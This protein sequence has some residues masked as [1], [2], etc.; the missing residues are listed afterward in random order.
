MMWG[1][2]R[3]SSVLAPLGQKQFCGF[4]SW[5]FLIWC[6]WCLHEVYLPFF[7]FFFN[8]L[9]ELWACGISS[10]MEL[11]MERL[12]S[13]LGWEPAP[14]LAAQSL[15][16][17]RKKSFLPSAEE[18]L[19]CSLQSPPP[20]VSSGHHHICTFRA[21][22]VA[23]HT[24]HWT[25][26]PVKC[27]AAASCSTEVMDEDAAAVDTGRWSC[28]AWLFPQNFTVPCH[29]SPSLTKL[30]RP[31]Q[32]AA[33]VCQWALCSTKSKPL[34]GMGKWTRSQAWLL[35]RPCSGLWVS[36]HSPDT[37]Q[38]GPTLEAPCISLICL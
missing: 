36:P 18:R 16:I 23:L 2:W 32:S 11:R 30:S 4:L 38:Q 14:T 22:L 5:Q 31:E 3:L 37:V 19:Y 17:E 28:P 27:P 24:L 10:R 34:L 33:S 21:C 29:I 6:H 9:A 8:L 26:T 12:S 20:A 1:D 15:N 35:P 25:H 13:W 7:F